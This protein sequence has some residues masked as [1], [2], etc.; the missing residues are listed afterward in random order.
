MLFIQILFVTQHPVYRKKT[1]EVE[2]TRRIQAAAAH[3][4]VVIDTFL[5]SGLNR[6]D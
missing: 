4:E 3:P 5:C 2:P 1:T 6:R